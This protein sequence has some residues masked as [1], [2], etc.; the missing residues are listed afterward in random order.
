MVVQQVL[1]SLYSLSV[2]TPPPAP[3]PNETLQHT[4]GFCGTLYWEIEMPVTL[5]ETKIYIQQKFS[6]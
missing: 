4:T 3:P 6:S 5:I 1:L 2:R